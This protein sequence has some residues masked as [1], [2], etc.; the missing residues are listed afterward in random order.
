M[1]ISLVAVWII[2]LLF[3][4]VSFF[5]FAGI[6]KLIN[7]YLTKRNKYYNEK[8]DWGFVSAV[9]LIVGIPL[10]PIYV[11]LL[12]FFA[13]VMPDYDQGIVEG[14]IVDVYNVGVF[15]KTD[16]IKIAIGDGD[17]SFSILNLIDEENKDDAL[18]LIGK[19][20]RIKYSRWYLA[21]HWQGESQTDVME[22]EVVE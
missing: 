12:P 17:F 18:V 1:I 7:I 9:F 3:L 8:F 22:I 2:G 15:Y 21:P 14:K 16:Q 11:L 6:I 20:V 19:K 13:G 4:V 10:I 5:A